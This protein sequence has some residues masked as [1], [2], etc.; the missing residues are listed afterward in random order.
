MYFKITTRT[1]GMGQESY[2]Q[3]QHDST[4]LIDKKTRY[5]A[6]QYAVEYVERFNRES[7]E[8]NIACS[9]WILDVVKYDFS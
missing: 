4:L 1:R 3:Y 7:E 8:A 6:I 9:M 5:E 2:D